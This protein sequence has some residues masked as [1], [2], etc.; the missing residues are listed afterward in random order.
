M[1]R[2]ILELPTDLLPHDITTQILP[3]SLQLA[4]EKNETS[5]QLTYEASSASTRP[6]L[7]LQLLSNSGAALATIK[8]PGGDIISPVF[9]G[10][11]VT[12]PND[13]EYEF[14]CSSD[15][16]ALLFEELVKP[17]GFVVTDQGVAVLDLLRE[18]I[19]DPQYP[20]TARFIIDSLER[21]GAEPTK[22]FTYM[23]TIDEVD[24]VIRTTLEDGKTSE[25]TIIEVLQ[26]VLE[27]LGDDFHHDYRAVGARIARTQLSQAITFFHADTNGN[28]YPFQGDTGD[29]Y[30]LRER[31]QYVQQHLSK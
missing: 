21:L 7:E 31:I 30:R 3:D 25:I 28:E 18:L 17:E 8:N 13:K 1:Q 24:F 14:T 20:P 23:I 29:V 27:V 11:V 4:F 26:D 6:S 19:H 9:S 15:D 2:T 12:Q 5:L 10:S 16:I 22:D